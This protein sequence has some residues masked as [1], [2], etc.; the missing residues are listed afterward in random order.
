MWIINS[1]IGCHYLLLGLRLSFQL[2]DVTTSWVRVRACSYTAAQAIAGRNCAV[3]L[4]GHGPT[5]VY[6]EDGSENRRGD[7]VMWSLSSSSSLLLLL[8]LC[9]DCFRSKQKRLQNVTCLAQMAQRAVAG[10][11][12]GIVQDRQ[13]AATHVPVLDY[14]DRQTAD[15]PASA[16]NPARIE[17]TVLLP[18]KSAQK[19]RDI[20]DSPRVQVPV[21][22][23]V[24]NCSTTQLDLRPVYTPFNNSVP[25]HRSVK[26]SMPFV[27]VTE[28]DYVY[29]LSTFSLM[30]KPTS[31][32]RQLQV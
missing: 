8:L 23:L 21:D 6:L 16:E 7:G 17:E 18:P 25:F 32:V 24:F 11:I 3:K 20:T 28:V 4:R 9:T 29:G 19:A 13:S 12:A 1:A 22:S 14:D 5:L 10:H 30:S 27:L 15:R 2:H 31:L 26:I